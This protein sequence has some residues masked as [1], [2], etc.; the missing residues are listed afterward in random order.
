MSGLYQASSRSATSSN[1]GCV[2]WSRSPRHCATIS[3][4]HRL[5]G[6]YLTG[7]KRGAKR[8]PQPCVPGLRAFRKGG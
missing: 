7:H 1:T 2:K 6:R 4:V 3:R 5:R 8:K